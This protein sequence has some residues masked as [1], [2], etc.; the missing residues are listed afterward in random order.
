MPRK[1]K[2]QK[3]HERKMKEREKQFD[4]R[5]S[6]E[7]LPKYNGLYDRNLRH[8]FENRR[9]QS[10]LANLGMIDSEGRVVNLEKAKG[11]VSIILQ[12]FKNAERAETI[13]LREEAEMRR[14]VQKKRHETLDRGRRAERLMK[15]KDDRKIRTEI[16]A[17]A[18]G[19]VEVP[20]VETNAQREFKKFR[21]SQMVRSLPGGGEMTPDFRRDASSMI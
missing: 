14:R 6:L 3:A 12:E 5:F 13:R 21:R 17:A 2:K 4:M 18:R 19:V 9:I 1:T 10:H 8:H 20:N 16:L 11:K 7:K 15:I